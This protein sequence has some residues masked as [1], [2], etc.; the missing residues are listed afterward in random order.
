MLAG[1]QQAVEALYVRYN[2]MIYNTA[3]SYVQNPQDAEEITQD[4]FVTVYLKADTFKGQSKLST[5]MYR[6]TINKAL[7]K[8]A[9]VKRRPQV[10]AEL[11]SY[12]RV[13]FRHPGILKEQQEKAAYLFRAIDTLADAQKTAFILTHIE[14]LPQQ[15][16]AAIM[17]NS[18]KSV[19]NLLLRARANLRKKLEGLHPEGK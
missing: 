18:L 15:E 1:N 14:G 5:W 3:L 6:I 4:V 17:N 12:H 2:K 9:K 19:E 13:E 16:V 8:L 10:S 11:K 7:D